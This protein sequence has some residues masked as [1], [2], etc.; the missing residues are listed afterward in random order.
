MA[1]QTI[2]LPDGSTR[3]L[4]RQ[5]PLRTARRGAYFFVQRQDGTIGASLALDAYFDPNRAAPLLPDSV[6]WFAKAMASIGQVL[7][8]DVKGCCVISSAGHEVGL[9]TGNESGAPVLIS[10]AEIDAAYAIWNP[11][12]QDNGCDISTVLNYTR[13][14]GLM[15]GGQLHKIDS[16]VAVDN[17][18]WDLCRAALASGG[19]LKLGI[20]LPGA[21]E[22][23]PD[24]GAW[25]VTNS[26]VVGGHDVPAGAYSIIVVAGVIVGIKIA[27][28]GGLR[29][30][31]KAA[32][33][34]KQYITECYMPLSPDWYAKNNTAPNG[35]DGATLKA[36]QIAI[37]NGQIPSVGPPEV[38][39][40]WLI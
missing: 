36:D 22:Q 30:I 9:W 26:R 18:N 23:A 12:R 32:F 24:N 21:W 14:H 40:D 38:P 7:R 1:V 16:Y 39:L 34:S 28:W 33:T 25:D 17:A 2:T 31:T 8:N 29:T 20:D 5:I 11:G 10:D 35:L 13:D 6:D 3:K 15:L 19:T 27:T 37:G 4:G